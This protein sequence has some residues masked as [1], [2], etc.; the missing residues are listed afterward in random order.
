MTDNTPPT[1]AYIADYLVPGM[2]VWFCTQR[3]NDRGKIVETLYGT[4]GD[5][6]YVGYTQLANVTFLIFDRVEGA[7]KK[8]R[9]EQFAVNGAHCPHIGPYRGR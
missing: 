4:G 9:T 8:S 3:M 2:H 7:G 5:I 1:T 6:T